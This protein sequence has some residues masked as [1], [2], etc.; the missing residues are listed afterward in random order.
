MTWT[1]RALPLRFRPQIQ[2]LLVSRRNNKKASAAGAK[3][4]AEVPAQSSEDA[5]STLARLRKP[6]TD[7][8]WKTILYLVASFRA[9]GDHAGRWELSSPTAR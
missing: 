3:A 2:T 9:R 6:Q 1:Q 4:A 7:Q 5:K 8:P